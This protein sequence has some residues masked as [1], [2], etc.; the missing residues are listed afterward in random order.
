M[1]CT[2][3]HVP[4]VPPKLPNGASKEH[5]ITCFVKMFARRECL[6]RLGLTC[7]HKAK[8]VC[9]C[10]HHGTEQEDF[11]IPMPTGQIITVQR[12]LVRI[13]IPGGWKNFTAKPSSLSKW[14]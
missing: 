8:D 10:M 3:I 13:P 2:L 6:D 9:F 1:I 4:S 11:Y 5:Q 7:Y 12:T 14:I